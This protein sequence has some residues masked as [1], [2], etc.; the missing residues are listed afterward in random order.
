MHPNYSGYIIA[1]GA[2]QPLNEMPW[3]VVS[4]VSQDMFKQR[5]GDLLVVTWRE[6]LKP[7]A[8]S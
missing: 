5:Q 4:S 7:E 1:I 8:R 3:K 6:E 2:I